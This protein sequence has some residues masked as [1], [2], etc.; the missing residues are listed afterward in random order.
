M[1]KLHTIDHYN[2]KH[3]DDFS[4]SRFVTKEG[5]VY[6]EYRLIVERQ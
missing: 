2:S 5:C 6:A 4:Y 3:A 1:L